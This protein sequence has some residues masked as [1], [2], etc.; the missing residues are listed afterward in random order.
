MKIGPFFWSESLSLLPP[1][2]RAKIWAISIFQMALG[3]LDLAGVAA[4]GLLGALSVTGIESRKPGNRVSSAL[5]Y[6]HLGDMSFQKQVLVIS[7]SALGLLIT[8]TLL[9]I[10]VTK[11]TLL[12]LAT[13]GSY[14]SKTLLGKVLDG[15]IVQ[16]Q[17]QSSQNLIYA[18]TN[19]VSEITIGILATTITLA[20]DLFLLIALLSALVAIDPLMAILTL[21]TFTV[22]GILLY[23]NTH[24]KSHELGKKESELN[25]LENQ[26][27]FE[28]M[29]FYREIIVRNRR[30][31]YLDK[32]SKI[33]SELSITTARLNL[34]PFVGKYVIE[35]SLVVAAVGIAG[36]QFMLNNA[37][38]AVAALTVFMAAGSRIAPAILRIQQGFLNLKRSQGRSLPT[39]KIIREF[40]ESEK[41]RKIAKLENHN[42]DEFNPTIEMNKVNFWYPE[43]NVPALENISITFN[44]GERVA[45]VGPS[46]SGKSTLVDLALGVIEPASGSILI[47][48]VSA[49]EAFKFWPGKVAYVPQSVAILNDT[50]RA[51]LTLGVEVRDEEVMDALSMVGLTQFIESLTNGIDEVIQEEGRNLSGGQRQRIGIARA[52]ISKPSIL[53]LDE[54]T[55]ALD[56]RTEADITK[57]LHGLSR[58]ITLIMIAH[59]LSTV[60]HSDR[61][62]YLKDGIIQAHGPFDEV[63]SL[64]PDF[65]IQAKLLGI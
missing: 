48:G 37:V 46:G 19:G 11:H 47:S 52:L 14:I 58:E 32:I 38:H 54:A 5:N 61:V 41:S 15:S 1:E 17:N 6:L 30:S 49:I 43:R 28:L 13:Q 53:I 57:V 63:R 36:I 45:I 62:I 60:L 10:V 55:S 3:I 2:S 7:I 18:L 50:V 29:K 44:R 35:A 27:I 33:Q 31:Y 12:F 42:P 56:S 22:V 9:S 59:R 24:K 51:N 34:I 25:I 20:S 40:H 39:F 16:I 64:V 65:D 8:R 23:Q 21:L 4:F 26:Q